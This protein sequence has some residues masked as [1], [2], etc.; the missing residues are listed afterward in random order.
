MALAA[1][2]SFIPT[3]KKPAAPVA[4]VAPVATPEP[5]VEEGEETMT[6]TVEEAPVKK[7]RAKSDKPRQTPNRQM[8]NDDIIFVRDNVKTMSYTQ[9]AEERGIT[10]HQV[11]R[12]LMTVKKQLRAAAEGD[13]KKLALIDQY[14]KDNLS[15]PEDT[16]P[17]KGGGAG[18]GS[19]VKDSIDDI[20]GNLLNSIIK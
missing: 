9:M 15:R 7:T 5:V 1:K 14:I 19:A 4:P 17:G 13:E 16:L 3:L 10:K 2:P 6:E 8:N 12:V 11:N 20:V 18:R